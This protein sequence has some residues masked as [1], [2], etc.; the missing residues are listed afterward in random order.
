[1]NIDPIYKDSDII[2]VNKPAGVSIYDSRGGGGSTLLDFLLEKFPEIKRVGDDPVRPGIVHRLDKDTSGVMVVAR[3]NHSFQELKILFQK[4]AIDKIYIA[5]VC[6]RFA[7]KR[8]VIF[9]PIGRLRKNPTKRGVERGR[10][11]IKGVREAVTEYRVLKEGDSYSLVE[12][13]PKTGRTHQIRVHLK[14]SGHPVACD[15]VYGGKNVCCPEGTARHLLHARSISFSLPQGRKFLFEAAP[16]QDF[17]VA[18]S[19]I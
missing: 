17:L 9:L 10:G 11:E 4:R 18:E 2:V 14:A 19:Q 12:L 16:P 13:R 5:I 7:K 3:N 15:V 6:G 1:M 8:G